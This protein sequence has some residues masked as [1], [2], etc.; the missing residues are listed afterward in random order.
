M[1][2]IAVPNKGR[3]NKPTMELLKNAGIEPN[4]FDERK[5]CVETNYPE[6]NLLFLRVEDIGPY[7]ESG[8]ADM[9]ITGLDTIAEGRIKVEKLLDL[10]YGRCKLVLAGQKGKELKNGVRISTK[11]INLTRDYLEAKGLEAEITNSLGATEIKPQLGLADFIVDITSTGSTLNKNDLEV[12]DVLLK[13]NAVLIANKDSVKTKEK[14]IS[15]IKLVLQSVLLAENKSYVMF[16]ISNDTLSKI[17]GQIPCMRAPTIVKT[18]DESVVSVQT[19]VPTDE[20]SKIITYLKSQGTT[21]ILVM[22]IK[23]VVV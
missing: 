11:F 13:S 23:R 3:M 9:G 16:N 19:V 14:N 18:G 15:D 6:L 21:D 20:V 2:N 10:N 7:V 17:I 4:D 22:E 12:Y 1:L 8:V 5:L